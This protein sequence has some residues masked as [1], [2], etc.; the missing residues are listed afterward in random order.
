MIRRRTSTTRGALIFLGQAL[1]VALFVL[2]FGRNLIGVIQ[3]NTRLAQL[4][5]ETAALQARADALT[6]ERVLLDD[7]AFLE[8]VAR[9]YSLGSAVERPFVL[10]ADAAPLPEDAPGSGARRFSPDASTRSPLDAWLD[11]LLGS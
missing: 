1:L 7:A 6:A 2:E 5:D 11:L 9:G 3:V 8:L 10:A 4:R